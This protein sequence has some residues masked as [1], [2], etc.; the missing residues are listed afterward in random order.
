M[1]HLETGMLLRERY[2]L[3]ERIG[4]G[5]A[6]TVWRAED[7]RLAGR[8]TALKAILPEYGGEDVRRERQAQFHAEASVLAR[9][10]HP[11]LPKV[12]D[13]F[14]D[15]G[16]DILV[17]DF[18]DGPDLRQVIDAALAAG[19]LLDVD[20][21][22]R[23]AEQL[24]DVVAYLH[25]QTP[26]VLHR[27]IKPA[28]I[29]LIAGERIKLVD[30]GLVK[31]LDPADPRTL[32]VARGVG[33]L[34]YTPLEQYAGDTGHTDARSDLYA[35]GATLY[36]LLTGRP[37]DTAQDRFLLPSALARPR[38]LNPDIPARVESAILS[39]MALHPERRPPTAEALKALL[40]GDAPLSSP[41]DVGT[42]GMAWRNA[43]WENAGL[44]ALV[45]L[46]FLLTLVA[47]W[48]A[49]AASAPAATP[50]TSAPATAV[51]TPARP[52]APAAT[53]P[54]GS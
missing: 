6:G 28:N 54:A 17:M 21:V 25:A 33:S 31:P 36:H 43:I 4:Q 14:E 9:L 27:D 24:L 39:A 5:G 37:P 22:V 52:T 46:L 20:R 1:V 50:T 35:V 10:D 8:M 7:L 19:E 30:F 47:T 45:A 48:Q 32:T 34:P 2:R 49:T 15:D 26:P 12:S 42:S 18:V 16:T 38:R 53:A 51:A 3:L 29:K 11:A 44:I 23:W 40:V 13:Y 41:V